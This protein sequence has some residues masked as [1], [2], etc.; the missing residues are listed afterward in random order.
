MTYFCV[1]QNERGS[2]VR[3]PLVTQSAVSMKCCTTSLDLDV[4]LQVQIKKFPKET[5]EVLE[6][7]HPILNVVAN[8]PI[9]NA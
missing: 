4:K 6:P 2:M 8:D 3:V 5:R 7:D 9:L 1:F